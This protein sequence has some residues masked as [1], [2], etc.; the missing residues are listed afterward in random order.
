MK[1]ISFVNMKG[2]VAKTTLAVN[3]ADCL[4][5]R[6]G[7]KVL[8]VDID[9]QFNATQCLVAPTRYAKELNSGFHTIID[10]FDDSPR[11]IVST[12]KGTSTKEPLNISNVRPFQ[13]NNR[14]H[15]IP[16]NLELYR[17]EM[18]AGQGRE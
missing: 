12:V 11:P 5:R 8:V 6:H 2:G 9:P 1:V 13:I 3:I 10:I 4:V 18:S 16:G 15:L 14:L 17:L 7:A